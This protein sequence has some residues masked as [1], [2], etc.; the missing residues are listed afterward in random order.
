MERCIFLHKLLRAISSLFPKLDDQLQTVDEW[1]SPITS[2]H[3]AAV[4]FIYGRIAT[5]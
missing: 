3:K 2:V 5:G 1:I 4:L